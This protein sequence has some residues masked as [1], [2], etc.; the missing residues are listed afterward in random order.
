MTTTLPSEGLSLCGAPDELI[1]THEQ[2]GKNKN[3]LLVTIPSELRESIR[4]STQ[5]GSPAEFIA[6]KVPV[7]LDCEPLEK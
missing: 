3:L 1:N 5:N 4:T 7:S 2:Q 6:G